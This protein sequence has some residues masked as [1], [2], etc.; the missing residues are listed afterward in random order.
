VDVVCSFYMVRF[1]LLTR[2]AKRAETL[3]SLLCHVAPQ[4]RTP[5]LGASAFSGKRCRWSRPVAYPGEL[6]ASKSQAF[7]ASCMVHF[8]FLCMAG[9]YKV[10]ALTDPA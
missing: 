6:V 2:D 8:T 9:V 10:G 3:P 4:F 5:K 1:H 7:I